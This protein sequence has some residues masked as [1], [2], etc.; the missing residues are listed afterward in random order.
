MGEVRNTNMQM[1]LA[2]E[3]RQKQDGLPPYLQMDHNGEPPILCE[4]IDAELRI[5][6]DRRNLVVWSVNAEGLY[7]GT[8]PVT[9]EDG[10]AVFTIGKLRPS[11][12]YL[13]CAQ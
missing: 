11:I 8:V 4:A 12:Y 6:T 10:C 13:I 2:P 3:S 5:R 1:S 7:A 9:Y